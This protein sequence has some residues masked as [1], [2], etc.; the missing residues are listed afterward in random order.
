MLLTARNIFASMLA[1]SL[2]MTGAL[3]RSRKRALSAPIIISMYCHDPRPRF[4]ERTVKWL[5]KKGFHFISVHELAA[6][7]MGEVA[8]PKGAV[9]LT[10]DDGW[11]NNRKSIVSVAN[12]YRIPVTIFV[13]TE[14][15]ITGNAYWWS[16]ISRARSAGMPTP[17]I[18]ALKKVPNDERVK[19]VESVKPA[20]PIGR[21]A[22]TIKELR[23]ISRPGFVSIE[24]HTITHPILTMCSDQKARIEIV[25]SKKAIESWLNKKI[26]AFAYPNGDFSDREIS[27]LQ[28]SGYQLAF[29]TSDGQITPENINDQFRLPRVDIIDTI[30]FSENLCR[31]TG[32]WFDL[33]N[34]LKY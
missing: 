5:L 15:V 8:F 10:V 11:R 19:I 16:Y 1:N 13:S 9:I 2:L 21:Q 25:Q 27:Y 31:I 34:K 3:R 4:F 6:I 24:S 12:R 22:F 29:T 17:T 33:K 28:D 14:P 20:I 26:I 23:E 32:L 18:E 7:A 30:S